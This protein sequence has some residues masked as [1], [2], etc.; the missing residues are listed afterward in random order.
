MSELIKIGHN[1]CPV[2]TSYLDTVQSMENPESKPSP[3]D[4]TVCIYCAAIL[5]FED[6]M[7]LSEF[8]P[9][10]FDTLDKDTKKKLLKSIIAV[11]IH[12]PVKTSDHLIKRI[13]N[14]KEYA[15]RV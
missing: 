1:H 14:L 3:K 15:S 6:D 9:V 12:S 10:L 13:K 11:F 4:L 5:F 8:P 7:D 2:C